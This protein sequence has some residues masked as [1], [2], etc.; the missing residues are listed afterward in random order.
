MVTSSARAQCL[1][2]II[3]YYPATLSIFLIA[4]FIILISQ[5]LCSYS[6]HSVC[7][8]S[9]VPAPFVCVVH[10]DHGCEVSV[11]R[12]TADLVTVLQF[13]RS[14]ASAHYGS[15]LVTIVTF[16]TAEPHN[17]LLPIGTRRQRVK[18]VS[19]STEL[20]Q[21]S[22]GLLFEQDHNILPS[23][24]TRYFRLLR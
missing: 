15:F 11:W 24:E 7:L 6:F 4:S 22:R 16:Y 3:L 9:P 17:Y 20:F 8:Q 10:T 21:H 19:A 14:P 12:F 2:N 18:N 23:L 13:Y 1:A 5:F